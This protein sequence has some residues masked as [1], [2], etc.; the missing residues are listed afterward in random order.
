MC[1]T[2]LEQSTYSD[3]ADSVDPDELVFIFIGKDSGIG[4]GTNSMG[5]G[6]VP[7]TG[8]VFEDF[9][10]PTSNYYQTSLPWSE[11]SG[12]AT[13][14]VPEGT[15]VQAVSDG[16][17]TKV[18][19][20]GIYTVTMSA[21][22]GDKSIVVKYANLSEISIASNQNIGKND[23]IGIAGNGGLVLSVYIDGR[24]V[25]PLEYFY[26]PVYSSG[27]AFADILTNGYIDEAKRAA[28]EAAINEANN[29]ITGVVDKWHSSPI[30]TKSVGE[31]TWWAYGRGWQ[32]CEINGTFPPGGFASSYGN[33]GD[34]YDR[35]QQA[36][37][38][39]VGQTA[40]AG[41]W[42]V[43]SRVTP[44]SRGKYYGHVAFVEAVDK[45]GSIWISESARSIWDSHDGTGIALR[46]IAAPYNYGSGGGFKFK[47]FVYLDSPL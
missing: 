38:F 47:G 15:I 3:V 13:L 32:Y 43:W 36:G 29:N 40:R 1:L 28:L 19:G 41:S 34:Y 10:S 4:L 33:G 30:N 2:G 7:G 8:S 17:I 6:W 22:S 21:K 18:E 5:G 12:S 42:V 39:A 26:Q 23:N 27:A 16:R 14:A 11:T 35:V 44:D 46:K 25:N 31:C 45:D 20:S 37:H 24:N 9:S